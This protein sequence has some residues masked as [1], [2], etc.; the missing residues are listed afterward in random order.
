M[1]KILCIALVLALMVSLVAC[2]GGGSSSSGGGKAGGP[3]VSVKVLIPGSA[4][5]GE[6]DVLA[7]LNE[8]SVAAI[9]VKVEN[10]YIPWDDWETKSNLYLTTGEVFDALLIGQYQ[11]TSLWSGGALQAIDE[12]VSEE[13]TPNLLRVIPREIFKSFSIDGKYTCYPAVANYAFPFDGYVVRADI[14]KNA[15]LGEITTI[16]ELEKY[17]DVC[18]AK[19]LVPINGVGGTRQLERAF[20]EHLFFVGPDYDFGGPGLIDPKTNKLVNYIESD[21]FK[22]MCKLGEKWS[23]AGYLNPDRLV[24]NSNIEM[25]SGNLG[26]YG[27]GVEAVE[28]ERGKNVIEGAEYELARLNPTLNARREFYGHIEI[29]S[30]RA[31]K[32]PQEFALWYDWLVSDQKYY[33]TMLNGLEGKSWVKEGDIMKFPEGVDASNAPYPMGY[34]WWYLQAQFASYPESWLPQSVELNKKIYNNPNVDAAE[35]PA[36]G[37]W[38]DTSAFQDALTRIGEA[39]NEFANPMI[40]GFVKYEDGIDKLKQAY[41]DAGVDTVLAELQKQYDAFLASKK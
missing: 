24:P 23:A 9:N 41:K 1:K 8:K 21:F 25:S 20:G 16:E 10:E 13:K 37:L 4:P 2:S 32:Y 39:Y 15:G 33:E 31:S 17:F 28:G 29:V 18:K 38:V 35:S 34:A 19:G 40:Q 26:A 3:P 36:L 12:Y 22:Y 30:P 5:E 27:H 11:L 14:R 6:A 7:W